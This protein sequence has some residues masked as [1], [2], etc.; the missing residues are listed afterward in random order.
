MDVQELDWDA[1]RERSTRS[2]RATARRYHL[3]Y[4]DE[5]LEDL[6]QES[7]LRLWRRA[8]SGVVLQRPGQYAASSART[9]VV[10]SI[11]MRLA[12]KRDERLTTPLEDRQFAGGTSPEED[13]LDAEAI[14]RTS[15]CCKALLT[16]LEKQTFDLVFVLGLSAGE[17]ANSLGASRTAI[18]TR[19]YRI[20]RK[21]TSLRSSRTTA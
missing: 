14:A 1:L 21:L 5:D 17:A 9:T 12:G 19:L 18:E 13:F 2:V 16:E 6:V 8:K 15:Q 10:D 3:R 7:L 4:H 11:R 20:R